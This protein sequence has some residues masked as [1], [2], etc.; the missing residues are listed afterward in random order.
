MLEYG[1]GQAQED[2]DHVALYCFSNGL[3]VVGVC[4][5]VLVPKTQKFCNTAKLHCHYLA[6]SNRITSYSD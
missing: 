6:V 2:S 4:Q 3:K 5:V 1:V